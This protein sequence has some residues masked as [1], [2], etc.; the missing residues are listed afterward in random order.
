M[1]ETLKI[2]DKAL[3]SLKRF[4]PFFFS[5]FTT[6]S[7]FSQWWLSAPA[8]P[9]HSGAQCSSAGSLQ[10]PKAKHLGGSTGTS[11]EMWGCN[12]VQQGVK[13][14]TTSPPNAGVPACLQLTEPSPEP[15]CE[16]PGSSRMETA[17]PLLFL[18]RMHCPSPGRVTLGD[19]WGSAGCT[20]AG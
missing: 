1:G 10:C 12:S 5:L 18:G 2:Y 4:L 20:G 3:P 6:E 11:P 13:G 14:V 16:T 15:V 7:C 9:C 8:V 19:P 17:Q